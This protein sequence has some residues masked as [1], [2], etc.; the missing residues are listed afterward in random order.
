M[1]SFQ[2]GR[3]DAP[4][5]PPTEGD[6]CPS[7]YFPNDSQRS[8]DIERKM[9]QLHANLRPHDQ[10]RDEIGDVWI[11]GSL[12]YEDEP[13]EERTYKVG[14][15]GGSDGELLLDDG[16]WYSDFDLIDGEFVRQARGK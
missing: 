11:R 16:E 6:H 12:A 9:R 13:E 10:P 15:I 5:G 14:N 2:C 4:L 8:H 7:C 1:T 3:C